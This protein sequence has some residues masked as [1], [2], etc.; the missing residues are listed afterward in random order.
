MARES[1]DVSVFVSGVERPQLVVDTTTAD[2]DSTA[3]LARHGEPQLFAE[4]VDV[5]YRDVDAEGAGVLAVTDQVTGEFV[6]EATV[7]RNR[8]T[9]LVEAVLATR[10]GGPGQFELQI[11]T[12]GHTTATY[13]KETLLVYDAAGNLARTRSLIPGGVEL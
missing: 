12:E 5:T 11:V 10:D 4:D 2:A 9:E 8:I 7:D 3:R 6:L 13:R 1:I